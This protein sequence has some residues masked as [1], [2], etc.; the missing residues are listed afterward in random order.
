[1]S[2]AWSTLT[3]S[4]RRR[5]IGSPLEPL[6][7]RSLDIMHSARRRA[8]VVL[9]TVGRA[10]GGPV[11]V[12][13]PRGGASPS[14]GS[15][16]QRFQVTPRPREIDP[17]WPEPPR[18]EEP[19]VAV[20]SIYDTGTRG[21]AMD[22][23][24]FEALNEEYRSKPLVPNPPGAD[25]ESREDRA[26]QRV[27]SVHR[28]ID[29][30]GKRTLELGCSAGFEVWYLSHH[31][32]SDAWGV[33]VRERASWAALSDE[34]THFVLADL[35][36]D[37]PFEPDFFDRVYSFAVLEHVAHP[38]S[39]LRELFRIMKPG[40]LAYLSANLHRGP[41]ASHLYREIFFPFPHLLFSDDVI[42]EFRLKHHGHRGGASWVNRL[43]WSQ[44]EDYLREIGFEIRSLKFRETPLDE[45]FYQ[46]FEDILGRYPKWDLT[47]DF[48]DAVVEKPKR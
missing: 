33:D 2:Q 27:A 18:I 8:G 14:W 36:T 42:S 20:R 19:G 7:R 22:L 24:L 4:L 29:L 11:G 47:K 28:I 34:R 3:R 17:N 35:A 43:T 6:A 32:G 25:Q 23:A 26:R 9:S 13:T 1:M 21:P 46:R 38:F 40:G 5:V 30:A 39:L 15:V 37:H 16:P 44:Y 31:L 41:K 48:F 12:P 10:I 45:A